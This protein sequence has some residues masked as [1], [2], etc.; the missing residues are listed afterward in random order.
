MSINILH[1]PQEIKDHII[2]FLDKE[3]TLKFIIATNINLYSLDRIP[4]SVNSLQKL[5]LPYYSIRKT[6]LNLEIYC[7]IIF[8]CLN[9]Q[10][11][12]CCCEHK[13]FIGSCI[14]YLKHCY[15]CKGA[16]C[17]VCC[18]LYRPYNH[19]YVYKKNDTLLELNFNTSLNLFF[20]REYKTIA[21]MYSKR[22]HYSQLIESQLTVYQY[23]IC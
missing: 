4:S 14:C 12:V 19:R 21:D 17:D 3:S 2:Q 8:K 11:F 10:K 13:K 7:K 9:C 5:K 15:E 18:T 16:G 23:Y 1:L 6:R 20:N 22:L